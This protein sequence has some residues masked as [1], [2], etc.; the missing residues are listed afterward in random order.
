MPKRL[1]VSRRLPKITHQIPTSRNGFTLVE[2][3]IVVAILSLIAVVGIPNLRKFTN[4]QTTTNSAQDLVRVFRQAKTS[5][6]SGTLCNGNLP[7]YWYVDVK[8]GLNKTYYLGANYNSTLC[9][10][11]PALNFPNGV[12][13]SSTAGCSVNQTLTINY[14]PQNVTFSCNGTPINASLIDLTL[15]PSSGVAQTIYVNNAGTVY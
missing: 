14:N 15:T 4:D 1:D 2:I 12:T 13:T 9:P 7:D 8:M 11:G 10:N 5:S 6:T 3:L